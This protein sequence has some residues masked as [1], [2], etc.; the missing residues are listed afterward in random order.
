MDRLFRIVVSGECPPHLMP[1]SGPGMITLTMK[2]EWK[3]LILEETA[4]WNPGE[5]TIKNP[6]I[7]EGMK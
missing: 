1:E 7:Q 3:G 5:T 4:K 2:E 6:G